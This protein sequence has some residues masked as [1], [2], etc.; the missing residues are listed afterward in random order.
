MNSTEVT[1]LLQP[2][3]LAVKGKDEEPPLKKLMTEK[4]AGDKPPYSP[5]GKGKENPKA[6]E[7]RQCVSPLICS[8]WAALALHHKVIGFVSHTT[9]R[10][11]VLR[12]KIKDVT[13]AYTFVQFE[14]T[15]SNTRDGVS[16]TQE[17]LN[18]GC[19]QQPE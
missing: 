18:C 5:G 16:G 2:K 11:T 12:F 19:R 8:T 1:T 17:G 9:S 7:D 13:R 10:N 14:V 6:K 15:S 4:P 3:P